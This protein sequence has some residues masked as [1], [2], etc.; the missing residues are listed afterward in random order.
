MAKI[1]HKG[2]E[3]DLI[4]TNKTMMKFE[5]GGGSFQDFEKAPI[6]QSIQFVCSALGLEG[7][8]IEHADDFGSLNEIA[9]SIKDA[10]GE[11]GFSD[12]TLG[13]TDG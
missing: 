11:S 9:E 1:T 2:K 13:K 5:M 4:I 10:L 8:P 6:S 3:V 12:E 7:D